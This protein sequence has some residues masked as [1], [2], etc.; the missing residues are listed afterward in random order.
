MGYFIEV[1]VTRLHSDD[2]RMIYKWVGKDLEGS[3]CGLIEV[4]SQHLPEWTKE[5]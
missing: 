4:L 1:S 3:S 5:N 2:A